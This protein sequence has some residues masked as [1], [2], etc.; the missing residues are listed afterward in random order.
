[1]YKRQNPIPLVVKEL[2]EHFGKAQG[3]SAIVVL[4]NSAQSGGI[5]GLGD[6]VPTPDQYI[7]YGDNVSLALEEL[8]PQ[9]LPP[10]KVIGR[11][12]GATIVEWDEIPAGYLGGFHARAKKP[13]LKRVDTLASGLP[14]GLQMLP[15]QSVTPFDKYDWSDRL[16]YGVGNRLNG[17]MV[18]LTNAGGANTYTTPAR[19]A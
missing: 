16:G 8:F 17:V 14:R 1:M 18:D 15:A 5:E 2:E 9:G 7:S 13:L 10:G 12:N 6:F 4:C 3:G 11:C 19:F